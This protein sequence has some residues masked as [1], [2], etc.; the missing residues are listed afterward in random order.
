[1]KTIY[2]LLLLLLT[3][4]LAIAGTVEQPI[5]CGSS[6]QIINIHTLTPTNAGSAA[7]DHYIDCDGWHMPGFTTGSGDRVYMTGTTWTWNGTTWVVQSSIYVRILATAA[8]NYYNLYNLGSTFNPNVTYPTGC[9]AVNPCEEKTDQPSDPVLIGLEFHAAYYQT[10][11]ICQG[12]CTQKPS[13]PVIIDQFASDGSG[14]TVGPWSFTGDQCTEGVTPPVPEQPAPEDQCSA[15]RNA[16]EAQCDGRPYV[17]DC[18]T[19]ACECGG[20]PG[21]TTDPPQDPTTPTEDPGAPTTPTAETPTNNPGGDAQLGAQID[22]QGKQIA[23]GNAQLGQLGAINGKLGAIISNQG[24]QLGQGDKMIDYQ[25]RQLGVQEEIRNKL[26][27]M[28]NAEEP[29]LPAHGELDTSIPDTKDWDEHDDHNAVGEARANRTIQNLETV[30]S[31]LTFDVTTNGS[32]PVLAGQM[33]GREIQIRFD[34]PWMETGYSIMHAIFIGI[35]Y[36]QVFLMI[37]RT[38]TGG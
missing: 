27:E 7:T 20:A 25:R 13:G 4:S 38:M 37:N 5:T 17:F 1:M 33:F 8:Q 26:N 35:G 31:P 12:G 28:A 3:A 21:Y 19:G 10:V 18:E 24:K 36:L 22:N 34:R 15:L 9:T 16:C 29:T 2:Y 14:Y 32:S 6:C 23:Q 30:E 11:G